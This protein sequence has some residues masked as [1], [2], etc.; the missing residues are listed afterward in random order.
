V[1][2]YILKEPDGTIIAVY[3]ELSLAEARVWELTIETVNEMRL[4]P[5][6]SG[7]ATAHLPRLIESIRN[8]FIIERMEVISRG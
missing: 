4:D 2:V 1:I 8:G 3:D 6:D 7:Y 5:E